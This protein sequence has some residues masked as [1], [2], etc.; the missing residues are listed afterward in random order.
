MRG[1]WSTETFISSYFNLPSI[2]IVYFGYKFWMK[3]EIIPLA[4]IPIRPFIENYQQNP[5]P[6]PAPKRGTQRL[7]ILWS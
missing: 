5:E 4:D 7:N 3:T 1:H 2:A 6:Q